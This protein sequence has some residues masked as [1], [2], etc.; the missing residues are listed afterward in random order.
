MRGGSVEYVVKDVVRGVAHYTVEKINKDEYFKNI[1]YG[2][3]PPNHFLRDKTKTTH[4]VFFGNEFPVRIISILDR[5]NKDIEDEYIGKI[6]LVRTMA[7]GL[8]KDE[9]HILILQWGNHA[10]KTL[11]IPICNYLQNDNSHNSIY[12]RHKF[13][14][15]RFIN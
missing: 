12:N 2:T 15:L 4:D 14:T 9:P 11:Q 5:D 7:D 6:G 1:Q 3:L 8:H 10:Y 13:S